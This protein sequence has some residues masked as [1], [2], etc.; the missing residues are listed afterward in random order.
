MFFE[1][2]NKGPNKNDWLTGLGPRCLPL[3]FFFFFVLFCFVCFLFFFKKD[4]RAV[5]HKT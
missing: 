1:R 2:E 5:L 4:G 3:G